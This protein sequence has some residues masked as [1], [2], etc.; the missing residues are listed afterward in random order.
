MT[1]LIFY[2]FLVLL[3]IAVVS[4]LIPI[5]LF[6]KEKKTEGF[7]TGRNLVKDFTLAPQAGGPQN[8][9]ETVPLKNPEPWS[10]GSI[11]KEFDQVKNE[12]NHFS[13]F[14]EQRPPK[15]EAVKGFFGRI[16][17]AL[18]L[19]FL[20]KEIITFS[21]LQWVAIGIGYYL[22]V[23]MLGWIPEE[24]WRSAEKSDEG[25]I[26]DVILIAW[27]FVCVG[28]AAF[29]LSIFSACMGAVHF[30]HKQGQPSTIAA[31]LRIVL[32]RAWPLWIFQWIDGWI[33]VNQ[34][35]ERLPK[36]DDKTTPAERA[37]SEALY[38]AWKVGTIGILPSLITG[39]GLVE[40]CRQSISI[41]KHKFKEV[42]TL[43]LG[44]SALC[45]I[46]GIL[47]YIGTIF[48]FIAFDEL[49]PKGKEEIYGHVFTFYFWAAV[50]ILIAVG[51]VQVF[52]RPI[53][54]ISAC[55]IYSDYLEEKKEQVMLPQP[56]AKSVSALV[57]FLVL[58]LILVVVFL[59]RHQLGIMD[60]LATP[61]GQKYVPR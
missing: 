13:S 23:Q 35:L 21:L 41:V 55:D 28:V 33:T 26:A 31:C 46:V 37:L 25:S 30:L 9:N 6:S 58:C 2:I 19:V 27:S 42:V 11:Q 8:Q 44:Y 14:Q 10:I 38:F 53:Y 17:Y 15:T 51:I 20:E 39:R 50:P 5:F 3:G 36:K 1:L 59:Y 47:A 16:G 12:I 60:M 57:A 45:W 34:I 43:R 22:W 29:P 4:Y 61:Y 7:P 52:L 18:K 32:P 56:P 24:V 48:F 40:S 54:L 49:I